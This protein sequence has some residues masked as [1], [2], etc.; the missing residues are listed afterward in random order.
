MNLWYTDIGRYNASNYALLKTVFEVNLQLF[1]R[2]GSPKTLLLF[3]IR[4]HV[5]TD[6]SVLE[7]NLIRDMQEIWK[8][9]DK[10]EAFKSSAVTDFFDFAFESFPHFIYEK[11]KF[12]AAA[13]RLRSRFLKPAH[14]QALFKPVYSK[15]VPADGFPHYVETIWTTIA[16]NK[17]LDIPTQKEMLANFRCDEISAELLAAFQE[18]TAVARATGSSPKAAVAP[19]AAAGI[20]EA[21]RGAL[22]TAF[23]N[24]DASTHA[25]HHEVVAKKRKELFAKLEAE[26][27]P[28]FRSVVAILRAAAHAHV[29]GRVEAELPRDPKRAARGFASAFAAI[30]SETAADFSAKVGSAVP[31]FPGVAWGFES[32]LEELHAGCSELGIAERKS[33]LEALHAEVAA[34]AHAQL[35]ENLTGL[36]DAARPTLWTE[37]QA[38][39]NG[40]EAEAEATYSEVLAKGYG[41]TDAEAREFRKRIDE[42]LV[43]ELRRTVVASGD[44]IV[45]RMKA[46]FDRR[47]KLDDQGVPRIWGPTDDIRA[48]FVKAREEVAPLVDLFAEIKVRPRYNSCFKKT[49]SF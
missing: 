16:E 45:P 5:A 19:G 6:M 44:I 12:T 27:L 35:H 29:R 43:E 17:D 21:F 4:D 41:P 40:A 36:L 25:Y 31:E 24:F 23:E 20:G 28:T 9:I 7:S 15:S 49:R 47:F 37:A 14:P 3:V 42:A 48:V 39:Y 30:V 11:D 18:A 1:A 2:E 38:L 32:A 13:G 22:A 33:H 10:P 8:S 46:K 26:A 34:F